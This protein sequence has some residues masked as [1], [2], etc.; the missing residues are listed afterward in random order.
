MD[1]N[2]DSIRV[3]S[4]CTTRPLRA[5]G[6][7]DQ[8]RLTPTLL[9]DE[10]P[11]TA[12]EIV[13][14]CNESLIYSMLFEGPFGGRSYERDDALRF[15]DWGDAGWEEETHFVFLITEDDGKV[16]G[17]I[18]IKSPEAASAEIG[19]WLSAE[20]SGVMTNAVIALT[21]LA[22]AAGFVELH[23]LVRPENS[24]S[25]RV[26]R[27]AGFESAGTTV[28]DGRTFDRFARRTDPS[29]NAATDR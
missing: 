12:D 2:D 22:R 3:T 1:D 5:H 27:R 26:L 28:R 10:S 11:T 6:R 29:L 8:Y 13:G 19:Y 17:A 4:L 20:H 18:D 9:H 16:A 21:E 25:A 14:I 7:G 24:R 15:L 23:A